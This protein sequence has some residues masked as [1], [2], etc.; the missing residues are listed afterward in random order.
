MP[1]S[2]RKSI[3]AARKDDRGAAALEFAILAAPLIAIIL[4]AL[5]TSII[6]FYDQALQTATERAAR[7]LM[8]GSAQ[9]QNLTQSQFKNVVC[10]YATVFTCSGLM[11]DVQSASSFTAINTNPLTPTYNNGNVT[12]TWSYNTGGAGDI[13][14]MRVMY[15]WPVFGGPLSLNLANQPNGT[16]L[17]VATAVFKNEP[18]Q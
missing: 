16:Y 2:F 13:V 5:Q 10:G 17:L 14:I 11:V 15:D 1:I 7:Q 12:N 8:T 4:A 9:T 3:S 6:F 18:Y